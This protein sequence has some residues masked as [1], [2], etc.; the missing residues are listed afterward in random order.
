[1]IPFILAM[2][3]IAFIHSATS[4][5]TANFAFRQ[6]VWLFI[7]VVG[8]IICLMLG[9]KFFLNTSY[10]FYFGALIL[11]LAV[12][13]VGS[14]KS[15]AQRWL[16]LGAFQL[17]P[18]EIAKL[19]TILALA[20]FLGNRSPKKNQ[21]LSVLTA[22]GMV[23]IPLVFIVIQPD[24][25]T[26]LIFLPILFCM[27]F[28]WGCRI[29]YLLV[30]IVMGVIS[31]PLF[32]HYFLREYQKRRLL[33]F[34]NP[35]IDPLGSGYTAIQ[36]KIAVGS[37][38]FFGK[39]WMEGTQNKLQFLPE[40]HTDFIFSVIGEEWGFVGSMVVLSLFII[41][42]WRAIDMM[43]LTTDTSAKLLGTGIISVFFFQV[44]INIGMT[45]G[46]MPIAGLP[47]PFV[48]YG[49]TSLL[50]SFFA[51]GLLLSIYKER[52]IF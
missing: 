44:L 11:L 35:N 9:Y 23:L 42:I 32:W 17:Q 48:S 10:L 50:T 39:G 26:S 19:A 43:H 5:M 15:G 45:I 22:F 1:V 36:S 2:I 46:L 16:E 51:I 25:G 4:H 7:A 37:G 27:L 14:V 13:S 33:V 38:Q 3:G 34:V 24:L 49:G 18:S 30:P 31:M 6:L 40:H 8:M 20:K 12:W 52:S 47:L 29:W 28:I 21:F 41:F